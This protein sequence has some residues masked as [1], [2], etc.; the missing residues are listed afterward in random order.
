MSNSGKA[1]PLVGGWV[2]GGGERYRFMP[3]GRR[4]VFMRGDSV[5]KQDFYL[6]D[7][8]TGEERALSNLKPG[9]AMRSFD[10]SPDGKVFCSTGCV[11]TPMSC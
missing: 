7:L 8:T 11:R 4:I 5:E 1:V 2:R 6:L 3:D 10:V 9:F